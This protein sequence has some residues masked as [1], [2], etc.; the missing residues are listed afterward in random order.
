MLPAHYTV[1]VLT[2]C[3]ARCRT[4]AIWEKE[5]RPMT[6]DE[7]ARVAASIDRPGFWITFT[8]GE[9]FLRQDLALVAEAL[10]PAIRPALVTFPTNA[11]FPDR[12]VGTVRRVARA[13]PALRLIVNVSLDEVGE[14]HDE[15]RGLRGN[16]ALAMQTL[17]DLRRL[18]REVPRLTIGIHTVVSRFNAARFPEICDALLALEPDSYIAE[19]AE[20][21]VELGTVGAGIGPSAQ[22]WAR[23][24]AHLRERL[25][26]RPAPPFARIV[27]HL[28]ERYYDD[29]RSLLETGEEIRPCLAGSA[30]VHLQPDGD[31]VACG[32]LGERL[33]NLRASGYDLAAIWRG[34][35]ARAVRERIARDRCRC[36]LA[37]QAYVNLAADPLALAGVARAAAAAEIRRLARAF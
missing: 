17:A 6:P 20:E 3:N 28:R 33:G 26:G 5:S 13:N 24:A 25:A 22:D 34:D 4:C 18:Q 27:A 14:R 23:A 29:V 11:T 32:V 12:V 37:A 16:W 15:I 31:V 2:A 35:A 9:P 10:L 36:P 30:S 7:Y 8:G 21:R 1:S 19:P